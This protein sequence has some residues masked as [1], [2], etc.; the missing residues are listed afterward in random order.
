MAPFESLAMYRAAVAPPAPP[1][2]ARPSLHCWDAQQSGDNHSDANAAARPSVDAAAAVPPGLRSHIHLPQAPP[3]VPLHG[4][5]SAIFT[6]GHQLLLPPVNQRQW[7][8][9]QCCRLPAWRGRTWRTNIVC[10][11]TTR[12][13]RRSAW[14]AAAGGGT[15]WGLCPLSL[16]SLHHCATHHRSRTVRSRSRAL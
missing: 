6:H 8:A 14:T 10:L 5:S 13:H 3:V 4:A 11:P 2:L 16:R 12:L 1:P 9:K 7:S 15:W